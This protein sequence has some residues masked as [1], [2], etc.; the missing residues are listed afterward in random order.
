MTFDLPPCA[1]CG[2]LLVADVEEVD[3]GVGIQTFVVG[4]SCPNGCPFGFAVCGGCG[5]AIGAPGQEHR[6]WC[7]KR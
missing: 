5:I 4:W 1:E 6:A 2:A 7:G 3:I